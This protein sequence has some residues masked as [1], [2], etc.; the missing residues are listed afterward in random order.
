MACANILMY[1]AGFHHAMCEVFPG[2]VC[3]LE[4]N[5]KTEMIFCTLL[6]SGFFV[7]VPLWYVIR[8]AVLIDCQSG[9]LSSLI[10]G[11][12]CQFGL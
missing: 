12:E 7:P 8:S 2:G 1:L 10:S 11:F 6:I 3:I 4:I 9:N 5:I